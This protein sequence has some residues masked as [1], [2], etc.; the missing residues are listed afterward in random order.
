[1]TIKGREN[2]HY[3]KQVATVL[4]SFISN[5]SEEKEKQQCKRQPGFCDVDKVAW[6][7]LCKKC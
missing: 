5:I 3:N 1:V 2:L 7:H 4:F 6:C